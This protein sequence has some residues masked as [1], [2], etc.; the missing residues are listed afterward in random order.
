LSLIFIVFVFL[1]SSFEV[2]MI[3]APK[4]G[5]SGNFLDYRLY[6]RYE[7]LTNA[8]DALKNSNFDF[9]VENLEKELELNPIDSQAYYLM[10]VIYCNEN[11]I[12]FDLVECKNYYEKAL[13]L[14]PKNNID[15]YREYLNVMIKMGMGM[16]DLEFKN[17]FDVCATLFND[18]VTYVK[19]NV[20]FTSYTT[21][22]NSAADMIDLMMPYFDESAVEKLEEKKANMLRYAKEHLGNKI[23]STF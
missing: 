11:F 2:F 8:D 20:H 16:D 12:N 23:A 5:F 15:Y 9:A 18:Y 6:P 10:G 17:H 7:Y 14:N 22:V 21:M 4:V 3:V 19:Y 1:V 13:K